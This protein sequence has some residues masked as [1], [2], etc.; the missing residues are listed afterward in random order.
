M[1]KV[2][3]QLFGSDGLFFGEAATLTFHLA[4]DRAKSSHEWMGLTGDGAIC[5]F[6]TTGAGVAGATRKALL[7]L[8]NAIRQSF[9]ALG[10]F[11]DFLPF[12]PV[13]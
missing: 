8:G 7:Q 2:N 3:V 12:G 10:R 5:Q 1:A 4:H 13:V 6:A 9:E 11:L